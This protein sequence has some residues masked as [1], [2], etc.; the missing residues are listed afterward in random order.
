MPFQSSPGSWSC[1][2]GQYRRADRGPRSEW[3][4]KTWSGNCS[5]PGV[6]FWPFLAVLGACEGS[7]GTRPSNRKPRFSP[8]FFDS[9][10][11]HS[12]GFEPRTSAF[13]ERQPPLTD[14]LPNDV[15][16]CYCSM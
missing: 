13:G 5:D 2:A 15:N 10:V 1:N 3:V 11:V 16:H 6:T 12:L 9:F 7:L 4:R 14:A 8:G